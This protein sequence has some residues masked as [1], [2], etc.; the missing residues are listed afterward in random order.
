MKIRVRNCSTC[1]TD[2]TIWPTD[3]PITQV[4]SDPVYY[5]EPTIVG[6]NRSSPAP[7]ARALQ[8]VAEGAVPGVRPDH[9]SPPPRGDPGR[10]RLVSR[11]VPI[12]VT[13]EP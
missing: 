10:H 12:K 1:G 9:A 7:D 3:D 4:D 2:I 8:A 13:I 5:R 6:A 11:G